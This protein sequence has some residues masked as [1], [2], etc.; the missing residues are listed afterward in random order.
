MPYGVNYSRIK[1]HIL[2]MEIE[3]SRMILFLRV[4]ILK[5]ERNGTVSKGGISKLH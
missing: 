1:F 5:I 4:T 2:F 3:L